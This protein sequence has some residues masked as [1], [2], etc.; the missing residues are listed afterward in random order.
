MKILSTLS[1][2]Y[3][4]GAARSHGSRP[5]AGGTLCAATLA[6]LLLHG[7]AAAAT[8][9]TTTFWDKTLLD[10]EL[11][12]VDIKATSLSDARNKLGRGYLVRTVLAL[13]SGRQPLGAFE[14][15]KDVCTVRELIGAMLDTYPEY[16]LTQDPGAGIIW[17]HPV[18]VP[19][20]SILPVRVAIPPGFTQVPMLQGVLYKLR[21]QAPGACGVLCFGGVQVFENAGA[22]PVTLRPGVFTMRDII[23]VCCQASPSR[24][25]GV[26]MKG[27][28]ASVHPGD[29]LRGGQDGGPLPEARPG[30]LRFWRLG[31]GKAG[32]AEPTPEELVDALASQD[33]HQRWV[34]RSYAKAE[35]FHVHIEAMINGVPDGRKAIW[36]SLAMLSMLNLARPSP[37]MLGLRRIERE[38]SLDTAASLDR[39]TVVLAAMEMARVGDDALLKKAAKWALG[40]DDLATIDPDGVRIA[41]SSS[42]VRG[43]LKE[44]NCAWP[45]LSMK[46]VRDMEERKLLVLF[47]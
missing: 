14:F 39:G 23:N 41:N 7:T 34:A 38:M 4:R 13:E 43:A 3:R 10:M 24:T 18:S 42:I 44:A 9:E 33:A 31:M 26:V 2:I 15:A 37:D 35:L 22:Y 25:F 19:Y 11:H 5:A 20:E 45:G 8:N 40:P 17:I 36:A 1:P 32:D 46:E 30:S 12:H 27:L 21:E 16:T 47:H 6:C 29:L 28:S